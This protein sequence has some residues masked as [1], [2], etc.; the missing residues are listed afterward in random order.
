MNKI[1]I[2]GSFETNK[3]YAYSLIN[4]GINIDELVFIN[5]KQDNIDKIFLNLS[6]SFFESNISIKTG[7]YNSCS[8]ASML[9]ITG[10]QDINTIKD[11]VK[12]TCANNF[13]GMYLLATDDVN[14][15]CYF[16]FSESSV[17]THKVIGIGT[18]SETRY[19][20]KI[21]SDR[22]DL[23][24]KCINSYVLGDKNNYIIPWNIS[25]IGV[26]SIDNCLTVEVLKNIEE[27]FKTKFENDSYII[28]FSLAYLTDVIINNKKEI[29]TVSAYDTETG[30][31]ISVPA[32]VDRC[33]VK[34][35]INI[36]LDDKGTD[37]MYNTIQSIKK[38]INL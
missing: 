24:Q 22:L 5:E 15:D 12:N 37:S 7:K 20:N 8:D 25:N 13:D 31:Y 17:P 9:V 10:N 4:Q 30:I 26:M 36:E 3:N 14:R 6:A 28:G 21:V 2:I 27:E 32:I 18:M 11:I 33:G 19:L 16:V 1:A 34:E 29:L 35:I 23:S 38:S